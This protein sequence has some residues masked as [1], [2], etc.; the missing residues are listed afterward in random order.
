MQ[1]RFILFILLSTVLYV[2]KTFAVPATARPIT[3]TQPDGSQIEIRLRGDEFFNYQTTLDGY[4]LK[5]DDN[6]FLVYAYVDEQKSII[7]S[8]VKASKIENRTL[9]EKQFIE[10]LDK[11]FD[12]TSVNK[13]KRLQRSASEVASNVKQKSYPLDGS[14]RSLVI[15][16]NF[17]DK[18][19][20][21]QNPKDAF[22]KMLN[23][24]GYSS[25]GGTGSA[26]DYFK[27]NSMGA[28]SPQFDVFGPYTLSKN[29]AYYG[30]NRNDEDKNP[31]QMI[32]DACNLA[33]ADGVDFSNYDT[34]ADGYVDNVFV[35][36]AGYNEAEGASA[37]TIW[38]HRWVLSPTIS[39]NGVRV[40]DYACTSELRGNSGSTMCGIGTFTHEF[41]H[42]LGLP[43]LYATDGST[44]HTLSDWSIMDMG[45]YLNK[46][47]TPPSYSAYE[48]FYLN[49]LTPTEINHEADFSLDT[50][51]T[52]NTA[53][54]ITQNGNHNLNG[55]NPNP[56]EFF[57]LENRQ[58]KGWDAYLPGHGMLITRINYNASTWDENTVNNESS[59]M[60]VDIMEADKRVS[61]T[62]LGGDPFPGTANVTSYTPRLRDGSNINKPIKDINEIDG[63]I[64]FSFMK[65]IDAPV[66]LEAEDVTP[67][68]FKAVWKSLALA[69]KYYLTAY[70]LDSNSN[71]LYI[72]ENLELKDSTYTFYNLSADSRYFYKVKASDNEDTSVFSNEIAVQTKDESPGK[73]LSVIRNADGNVT[74]YISSTDETL[75]IYNINGQLIRQI[76]T[77]ENI[78]TIDDL[79]KHQFYIF[80]SG[81]KRRKI[82]VY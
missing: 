31:R 40:Y 81:E 20:V 9:K 17:S 46:G 23:E 30:E 8:D 35:F 56:K 7:V 67:Y 4:L 78:I 71:T 34:D 54:I 26:R 47:R 41:G 12:F 28:F 70:R 16:V 68:S 50:L 14:P 64:H 44:H 77:D 25:N 21:T 32:I 36:Y 82:I 6:G 75:Y 45:P 62:T 63:I 24:E 15:L 19:F 61:D 51:A 38:P 18:S 1:K 29:M 39:I 60:G 37:N 53:Y 76:K 66:A 43:D 80:K 13:Q 3:I 59:Q 65:H 42:V 10:S 79:P 5:T 74:V 73:V 69:T 55:E 72:A 52:S 22:T 33:H 58:Q 49:W 57:L 48:R 2:G 11:N 27:S